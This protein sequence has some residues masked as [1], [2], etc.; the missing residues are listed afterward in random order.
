[1][2]IGLLCDSANGWHVQD[3]LRAATKLQ[4]NLQVLD[5]RALQSLNGFSVVY[6]NPN[7]IILVRIMPPGSLEQVIFRMDWLHAQ[8]NSGVKIFNPPKALEICI[9]KY[10]CLE[11]LERSGIPIPPTICCQTAQQAMEAWENLG[12][13]VVVKPLFGSEGR[14]MMRVSDPELAW[15]TFQTLERLQSILYLQRFIQHPGWDLRVFVLQGRV[16][17]A[18]QRMNA[19]DWRTNVAQGGKAIPVSLPKELADLALRATRASSAIIAG[20][21]LI[22]DELGRWCVIEVNAV[23]GWKSLSSVT[24]IDIA[25]EILQGI[26]R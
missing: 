25:T 12:K 4:I 22:A 3:L 1:M 19:K 16:L 23:P 17:A 5:Y 15:R 7:P 24:G 10:L 9:D 2:N 26:S 8:Q 14:G 6:P 18:M 20:V 11:R 21:D 13:D